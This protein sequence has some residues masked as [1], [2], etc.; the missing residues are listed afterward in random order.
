M[1]RLPDAV[2]IVDAKLEST[3]VNEASRLGIPI[4]ALIDSNTDP[5]NIDFP[6]PANDDSIRTIQLIMTTIADTILDSRTDKKTKPSNSK[7]DANKHSKEESIKVKVS[8]KLDN[9]STAENENKVSPN[10]EGTEVK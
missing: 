5:S 3:A 6:I 8:N 7:I 9:E 2:I 10:Q 4:I 1:R